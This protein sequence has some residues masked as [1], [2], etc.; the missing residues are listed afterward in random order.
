MTTEVMAL[1]S[2]LK[3]VVL[4]FVGWLWHDKRKSDKRID[5]LYDKSTRT[6]THKEVDEKIDKATSSFRDDHKEMMITI[7]EMSVTLNQLARDLAVLNALRG[8]NGNDK[9]Q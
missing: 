8:V 4:A 9:Q 3:Y 1:T 5:D 2:I 6:P 7:R